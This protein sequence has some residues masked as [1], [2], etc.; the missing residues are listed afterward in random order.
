MASIFFVSFAHI[1]IS[2]FEIFEDVFIGTLWPNVWRAEFLG[3]PYVENESDQD[4]DATAINQKGLV[5]LVAECRKM[6]NLLVNTFKQLV[7]IC[8]GTSI[9]WSTWPIFIQADVRCFD[10]VDPSVHFFATCMTCMLQ[11][12]WEDSWLIEKAE[13]RAKRHRGS[14]GDLH[15]L[16]RSCLEVP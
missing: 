11:E 1:F 5:D 12:D 15:A 9:K 8:I 13:A 3:V 7:I 10:Q 16:L 2:Y 6:G 14:T 4:G